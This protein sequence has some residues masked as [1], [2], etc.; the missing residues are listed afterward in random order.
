MTPQLRGDVDDRL[1]P[2]V[3][4]LTEAAAARPAHFGAQ[5]CLYVDGERAVDVVVG[6]S[7]AHDSVTGVYSATKGVAAL[8]LA[9]LIDAGTLSLDMV[10]ADVWPEFAAHGKDAL[11]LGDVLAHRSGLPVVREVLPLASLLDS[12]IAAAELA[13]QRPLWRPGTAFGYHGITIGVLIEE[14]VRRVTGE[15]LRD[16]HETHVRAPRDADF[17]IGFPSDEDDRYVPV[18]PMEPT[19]EQAAELAARPQGDPVLTRMFANF[20]AGDEWSASGISTNNPDVRAAGPAGIGG[21]GSARGL[22]RL[23][24][25]ALPGSSDPI[26][27]PATF[28]AMRE[29]R[30]WGTDRTLGVTNAFGA[31]FMVPQPRMPFGS[32]EAFG[33]D[34]GGGALAFADPETG[35]AFGYVPVP[36]QFPGGADPVAVQI[37]RT[38]RDLLS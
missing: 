30:S 28:E 14:V 18:S 9:R 12:G 25:D 19:A 17:F 33:H 23:Y 13:A 10:V 27:S 38:A 36:M 29:M 3:A 1:A 31:V 6:G 11:T 4:L 21:V 7:L 37:A 32:L 5:L 20:E 34:G 15:E 16:L 24:A 26:A 22:A 2:A 8:T 35:L